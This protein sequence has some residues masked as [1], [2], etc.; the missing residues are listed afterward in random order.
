MW[1]KEYFKSAKE[2]GKLIKIKIIG[3][4]G[5]ADKLLTPLCQFLAFNSYKVQV[6]L[7]DK[8]AYEEKNAERQSF[9]RLGNKAEVMKERLMAE[10]KNAIHFLAEPTY[11]DW[12]NAS[13]LIRE[14]DIVFYCA[15]N[16]STKKI[17]SLRCSELQNVVC[18]AGGNNYTD[19]GVQCFLRGDG[20]NVTRPFA[21]EDHPEVANAPDDR[22]PN[23]LARLAGCEEI[24]K[25]DKPQ[26]VF[27]NLFVASIMLNAFYA[28]LQGMLDYDE[29]LLDILYNT[30]RVE[31][32]TNPRK[33]IVI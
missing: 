19:G 11:L 30:T 18:I 3:C 5:V 4:G 27:T 17:V 15:D 33:E 1:N 20:V 23:R 8:D 21:N 32:R 22:H 28:L 31:W 6:T 12:N 16:F 10:T 2:T 29:V 24:A 26:L 7:V 14:N 9:S 13:Q 25:T